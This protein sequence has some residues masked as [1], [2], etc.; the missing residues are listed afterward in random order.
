[1]EL[2]IFII[3]LA[4]AVVALIVLAGLYIKKT[5]LLHQAIFYLS[6]LWDEDKDNPFEEFKPGKR[7]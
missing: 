6:L 4:V 5:V 1:M 3:A 7:Q 2:L